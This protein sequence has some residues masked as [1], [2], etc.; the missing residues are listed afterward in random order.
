MP[1]SSKQCKI[2]TSKP[3]I[4]EELY[5]YA[6]ENIAIGKRA[7]YAI[8]HMASNWYMF[9]CDTST[10]LSL[11]YLYT[12]EI[13][14]FRHFDKR[15]ET[16]ITRKATCTNISEEANLPITQKSSKYRASNGQIRYLVKSTALSIKLR[17]GRPRKYC[18][19]FV[20]QTSVEPRPNLRNL[21]QC[22][23]TTDTDHL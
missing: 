6:K 20:Q 16:N 13:Q 23:A 3:S 1:V 10:F 21:L 8:C 9:I 19:N 17:E 4:L 11:M 2:I 22:N 15:S 7:L 14:T 5:T 12:N 18:K